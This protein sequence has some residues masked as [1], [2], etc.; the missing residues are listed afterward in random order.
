MRSVSGVATRQLSG[1]HIIAAVG[2]MLV[3]AAGA[4]PGQTKSG[5]EIYGFGQ[6]DFIYDFKQNNPDWYDVNRPSRL[7]KFAGE[8][9]NDHRSWISAR[10]SR[11][12]AKGVFPTDH[13]DIK[14][15][16]EFDLFGV[17]RDAGHFTIRPRHVYATWRQ[18][19]AGQTNSVFMDVDVFPNQLDYWGPNGMLFFRN[20]QFWWRPV[21]NKN[22]FTLAVEQSGA[23]GDAGVVADRIEMVNV[24]PRYPAPDLTAEYRWGTSWGYVELGGVGRYI[25]IDDVLGDAFDLNNHVWGWGASLS[26]NI[27]FGKRDVLRPQFIYGEGI[28][29]YFNDAPIDVGAKSNFGNILTPVVPEALPIFGVSLFLDHNWNDHW[30]T[31]IG[32]SMN[33]TDNS[34]LQAGNAFHSGQYSLVNL[35]WAPNKNF[36]TGGEF[37]WAN[38]KNN[39]DGFTVDDWR[40]QY[41]FKVNFS[42]LIGG[43]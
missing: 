3:A 8:F 6:G 10:Q 25:A 38:R 4:A 41:S 15:V 21:D 11:F 13:G 43:Q 32:Y 39:S 14:A 35:L 19:G 26:S 31:A 5:V 42:A 40:I 28:Q 2:F 24:R 33:S 34:D 20:V 36:M 12:G 29:N 1:R 22:R 23:S 18:F 17:G 16:F 7:P 27:R 37:Q 9:G 30:S